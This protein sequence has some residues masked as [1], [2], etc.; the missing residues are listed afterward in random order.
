MLARHALALLFVMVAF[1]QIAAHF[2]PCDYGSAV[3]K[4]LCGRCVK[5]GRRGGCSA[6]EATD[7]CKWI[8][9]DADPR[10][11]Q[12]TDDLARLVD[13]NEN[14]AQ[15]NLPW[16]HAPHLCPLDS[17]AKEPAVK[18]HYYQPDVNAQTLFSHRQ[19]D[20]VDIRGFCE[21]PHDHYVVDRFAHTLKDYTVTRVDPRGK[22]MSA[23]YEAQT[24]MIPSMGK[25]Y[26]V[27]VPGTTGPFPGSQGSTAAVFIAVPPSTSVTLTASGSAGNCQQDCETG[28]DGLPG[29]DGECAQVPSHPIPALVARFETGQWFFVGYGPI[30]V[31]NPSPDTQMNLYFAINDCVDWSDN[32]GS[33]NVNYEILGPQ[34]ALALLGAVQAFCPGPNPLARA[35][36]RE[37]IRRMQAAWCS[38]S[39]PEYGKVQGL[40]CKDSPDHDYL[41]SVCEDY[42]RGPNAEY[43]QY[44]P[45]DPNNLPWDDD[46]SD[47]FCDDDLLNVRASAPFEEAMGLYH[48]TVPKIYSGGKK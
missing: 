25:S 23:C 37:C 43:Y 16:Y 31:T 20:V 44:C 18:I 39:C 40:P 15:N 38:V 12:C 13:I 24:R 41:F 42:T 6:C 30:T 19:E 28:P 29:Q 1:H 14:Y 45:L 21:F 9:S 2:T 5:I 33:F 7:F 34:N 26:G 35:R 10:K 46:E 47:V 22:S 4:H 3:N 17:A 11:G 48:P 32:V 8:V 27:N 36:T